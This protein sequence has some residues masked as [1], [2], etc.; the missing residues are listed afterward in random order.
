MMEYD[1]MCALSSGDSSP[2]GSSDLLTSAISGFTPETPEYEA[3]LRIIAEQE[4]DDVPDVPVV[5]LA[6][7]SV[8]LR[9]ALIIDSFF[10]VTCLSNWA[11]NIRHLLGG[12][13]HKA[14]SQGKT[15]SV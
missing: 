9:L 14:S 7:R 3:L 11:T 6:P 1:L 4:C 10:L 8:F 15:A 12:V 13:T 5:R 2:S